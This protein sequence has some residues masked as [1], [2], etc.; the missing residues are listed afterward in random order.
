MAPY[1]S[2]T[3]TAK[4]ETTAGISSKK[5]SKWNLFNKD[6]KEISQK[7]R[8]PVEYESPLRLGYL[9]GN[10]KPVYVDTI[11]AVT[12]IKKVISQGENLAV[13]AELL[14]ALSMSETMLNSIGEYANQKVSKN[15]SSNDAL[16]HTNIITSMLGIL[17]KSMNVILNAIKAEQSGFD[18]DFIQQFEQDAVRYRNA[19]NRIG[20]ALNEKLQE[21]GEHTWNDVITEAMTEK[22]F[23]IT[24]K[25]KSEKGNVLSKVDVIGEG[26]EEQ[27]FK[28]DVRVLNFTEAVQEA[29]RKNVKEDDEPLLKKYMNG[30]FVEYIFDDVIKRY[31]RGGRETEFIEFV[32]S[33]IALEEKSA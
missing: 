2:V 8:E 26:E 11:S 25:K 29:I 27:F 7:G 20:G 31:I 30:S 5:S 28:E 16:I 19:S 15:N 13:N 22:V 1:K 32:R 18:E 4:P 23:D 17:C 14:N 33:D 21:E 24:N 3:G 10:L 6:T 12:E 9:Q